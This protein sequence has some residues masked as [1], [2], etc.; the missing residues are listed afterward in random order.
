MNDRQVG[1]AFVGV[2]IALLA[3]L[4]L[5]PSGDVFELPSALATAVRALFWI[6]VVGLVLGA[7]HLGSS[8]TPTPVPRSDGV[9]QTSGVY[10]WVRHPIYTAVLAIVV[11]MAVG[12]QSWLA[13][14]VGAATVAF[15]SVKARWEERR[16]ADRY[17]EYEAYRS[18][19]GR[20]LPR[21]TRRDRPTT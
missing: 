17:P 5:L 16:L 13:L 11:S 8:L 4:F 3:T 2:Q 6:G 9:L 15:F 10:R 1:W 12:R 19:T 7:A 18:R 20:F 21:I 14:S